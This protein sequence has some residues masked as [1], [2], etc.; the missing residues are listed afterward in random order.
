MATHSSILAWKIPW[1]EEPGGPQS[2]GSQSRPRLSTSAAYIL[3]SSISPSCSHHLSSGLFQDESLTSGTSKAARVAFLK[4]EWSDQNENHINPNL[5]VFRASSLAARENLHTCT[6][7]IRLFISW[8]LPVYLHHLYQLS[9]HTT[10]FSILNFQFN[11]S[12][13]SNSLQPHE[14]QQARPPCPSPSLGVHSNSRPS[15]W[16]CHPAISSSVVPCSSCTQSLPASGSFPMSQLFSWCGQ[17]TGVS[18]LA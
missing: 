5:N 8:V 13:V 6:W 3:L 12:V 14:S 9:H 10:Y 15:S 7:D 16:W 11:S 2:M 18:A 17:S 4:Y 1:T